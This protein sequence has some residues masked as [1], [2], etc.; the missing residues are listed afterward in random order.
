V[1]ASQVSAYTATYDA[2]GNRLTVQELDGTRA[3]HA[4]GADMGASPGEVTL[5]AKIRTACSYRR[6]TH[7]VHPHVSPQ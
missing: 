6:V 1:I 3:V 5:C 7:A 2:V 4:R